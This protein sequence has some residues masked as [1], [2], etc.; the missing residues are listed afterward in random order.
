MPLET[1]DYIYG[2]ILYIYQY[3]CAYEVKPNHSATRPDMALRKIFLWNSSMC[4]IN[5]Y[6]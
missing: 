6:N 4:N 2:A 1:L 3:I 5:M